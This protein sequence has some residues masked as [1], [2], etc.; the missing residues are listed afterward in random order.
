MKAKVIAVL[1]GLVVAAGCSRSPTN[2]APGSDQTT[3]KAAPSARTVDSAR[4]VTEVPRPPQQARA[5]A[6]IEKCGGKIEYDEQSPGKPVVGVRLGGAKDVDAALPFLANLPSLRSV[7][8][9]VAKGAESVTDAGLVHFAEMDRL[10]QLNLANTRISD[11]GLEQLQ[12]L[13]ALRSLDLHDTLVTD[14]G[15]KCLRGLTALQKLSLWGDHITDSGLAQ[16]KGLTALDDLDLGSTRVTAA[17]LE[18]LKGL[19][20]LK[21]LDLRNSKVN[22]A[23]F[24]AIKKALPTAKIDFNKL[25][26]IEI[27]EKQP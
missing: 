5:I 26:V 16:I 3:E 9:S 23:G 7:D 12:S 6:E 27:P 21:H 17:G 15:M 14:V 8:L 4:V 25:G 1:A 2:L 10:Q 11:K 24:E 18:T 20:N 22:D 19:T 13:A